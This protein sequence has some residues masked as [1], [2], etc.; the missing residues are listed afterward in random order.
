MINVF[1]TSVHNEQDALQM[2]DEL[3]RK[4]FNAKINFDLEDCD[5]ILRMEGI[6]NLDSKGIIN[7]FNQLGYYCEVLE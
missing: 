3:K 2:I 1:K 6:Q 4:F 7:Y 5:K